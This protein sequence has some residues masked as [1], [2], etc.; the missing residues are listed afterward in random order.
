MAREILLLLPL[1][2]TGGAR[3]RVPGSVTKADVGC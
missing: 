1:L 3:A 2:H